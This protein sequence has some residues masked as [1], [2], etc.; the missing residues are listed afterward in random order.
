MEPSAALSV[1][2]QELEGPALKEAREKLVEAQATIEQLQRDLEMTQGRYVFERNLF[3]GAYDDQYADFSRKV[4][5]QKQEIR[6]LKQELKKITGDR[7][8]QCL[9]QQEGPRPN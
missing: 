4:A 6:S 9:R 1:V 2:L 3:R 5:A 8:Q 7:P